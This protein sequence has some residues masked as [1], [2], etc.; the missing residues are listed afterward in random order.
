[1][2]TLNSESTYANAAPLLFNVAS[3]INNITYTATTG[4]FTFTNAG[5]YL[6]NWVASIT[7]EGPSHVLSLGLYQVTP[8]ASYVAYSNT[9]NTIS[10]NASTII[11]GTAL[12]TATAGST[13]QLRNVSGQSISTV[14]NS[15][16]AATITITRIN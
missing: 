16:I 3:P 9:G 5:Q 7:N 13:Y 11:F 15:T 1:M 12:V 14:P 2:A 10:S 4:T 6:I 8:S